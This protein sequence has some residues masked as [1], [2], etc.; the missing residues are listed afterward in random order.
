MANNG[1]FIDK[2]D[3]F[4]AAGM[5]AGRHPSTTG[6]APRRKL[7]LITPP[8]DGPSASRGCPPLRHQQLDGASSGVRLGKFGGTIRHIMENR[9]SVTPIAVLKPGCQMGTTPGEDVVTRRKARK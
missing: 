3:A 9:L 8:S 5:D 6:S 2:G 1:A 4:G 7:T